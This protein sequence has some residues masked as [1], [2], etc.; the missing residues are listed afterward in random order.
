MSL[1]VVGF[2]VSGYVDQKALNQNQRGKR[3]S[4]LFQACTQ[5]EPEEK[6]KRHYIYTE[7]SNL[8]TRTQRNLLLVPVTTGGY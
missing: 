4:E 6:N 7:L 3:A 1:V 5:L 8:A 2:V